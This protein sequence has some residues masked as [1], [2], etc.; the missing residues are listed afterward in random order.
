MRDETAGLIELLPDDA[1]L[2]Y[3]KAAIDAKLGDR[4]LANF[5]DFKF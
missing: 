2:A 5:L 4:D 3:T 1:S